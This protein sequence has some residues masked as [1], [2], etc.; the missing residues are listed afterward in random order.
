V[1]EVPEAKPNGIQEIPKEF[2][3]TNVVGFSYNIIKVNFINKT[4]TLPIKEM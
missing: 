3:S 1:F 4:K 2:L